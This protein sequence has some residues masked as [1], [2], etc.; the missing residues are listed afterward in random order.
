MPIWNAVVLAATDHS[1]AALL[2]YDGSA[3][4]LMLANPSTLEL[5]L[6]GGC[7][8]GLYAVWTGH[9]SRRRVLQPT[10][11]VEPHLPTEHDDR[12]L[13]AQRAA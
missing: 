10:A 1:T 2:D 7:M 11:A 3:Q 13:P 12:P 9:F 4:P 6:I 5:A 8:L